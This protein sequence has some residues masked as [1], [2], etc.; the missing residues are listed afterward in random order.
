[1]PGEVRMALLGGTLAGCLLVWAGCGKAPAEAG[2]SE[3]SAAAAPAAGTDAP[4][5]A[6]ATESPKEPV[7]SAE[8]ESSEETMARL[9]PGDTAI[10]VDGVPV[11]WAQ[12]QRAV[13][14]PRGDKG[15]SEA[16][17]A[18]ARAFVQKFVQRSLLLTEARRRGLSVSEEEK[19]AHLARLAESLKAS[20]RTVED[21]LK[22]FPE[23][24]SSPLEIS[25]A[26][27]LRVVKLGAELTK[28]VEVTDA[29]V[30]QAESQ[31]A[32]IRKGL[33]DLNARTRQSLEQI[34]KLPE[35]AT[36]E[37]FATLARKHSE[38]REA[39]KG[40]VVEPLTRQEIAAADGGQP[41]SLAAGETSPVI[42]TATS[43]RI[44]RV[45][46]VL[47]AEKEGGDERLEI[48][49]ILVRKHPVPGTMNREELRREVKRQKE[50]ELIKAHVA[51]LA[52]A[53]RISCPLF[54]GMY[55]P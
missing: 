16:H 30:S 41:F 5:G 23:K 44:I 25:L 37:G 28:G 20:G 22:Q 38:G 50:Q 31:L 12:I 7:P 29:E 49:Q 26:D 32:G 6:S 47:P 35:V 53:A 19:A 40:G 42:E 15:V 13:D 24:P 46:R 21:Y 33:L 43:F 55:P 2:R 9:S 17:T 27:T 52:K 14:W 4:R 54:P 34:A 39:P 48:A 1:M 3:P 10:S 18:K 45:L 8:P 51:E 11:T 36:D